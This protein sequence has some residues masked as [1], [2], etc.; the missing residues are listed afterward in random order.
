MFNKSKKPNR[1][2]IKIKTF[3]DSPGHCLWDDTRGEA[4]YL[5]TCSDIDTA[6]ILADAYN[7]KINRCEYCEIKKDVLANADILL[8]ALEHIFDTLKRGE[9][10]DSGNKWFVKTEHTIKMAKEA[11]NK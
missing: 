1:M 4:G 3:K 11:F 5:A 6:E 10:P 2:E 9:C 7:N 8:N